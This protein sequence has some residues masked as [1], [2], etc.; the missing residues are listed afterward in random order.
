MAVYGRKTMLFT[1]QERAVRRLGARHSA[2][3]G[4]RS[5]ALAG[6]LIAA[7]IVATGGPAIAANSRIKDIADFEGIRDNQLVGYGLVVGLNGT[8]DTLN[9]APFTQQSLQAMLERFGINVRDANM[10]T[11][12]V[13]AVIVTAN[14]PPFARQGNRID[15]DVSALGDAES[16]FG[17]TLLVSPLMAAD[18][19]VYAVGQGPVA[20][21]GFSAA[22][23]AGTVTKNVPTVG[24]IANGAIVERETGFELQQMTELRITLRNPDLT[25]SRRVSQAINRLL[26]QPAAFS[27][28]P[29][30]VVLQ[31]PEA[32]KTDMVGLLAKVEQTRVDT[33]QVARV[34]ID[35]KAGII[36]I[37]RE[38]R[39]DPLAISQGNLTVRVTETQQVSQPNA[40]STQGNT[41][42][43]DRTS[44]EINEDEGRKIVVLQPGVSLQDL[45]DGLNALG[46]GP[47]DMISILQAI[48]A[49]GALQADIKVM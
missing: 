35:E 8:G 43:V 38:V 42:V 7:L 28:D 44:V 22:G 33:D 32:Y 26:G 36:V 40:F 25:T 19:E 16:L 12:N 47:R 6:A 31:V 1:S 9:N 48:K 13:A 18:G 45:V 3:V 37:G 5:R 49:V 14:L 11:Q 21:G 23:N 4:S 17:G 27:L 15:I 34:I 41:E 39:I 46:V 10:R 29:T 2:K 20:I 24:R 30:T